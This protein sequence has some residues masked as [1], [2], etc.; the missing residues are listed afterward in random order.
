MNKIKEHI[1]QKNTTQYT[2]QTPNTLGTKTIQDNRLETIQR[3]K[4]QELMNA[5]VKNPIIQQKKNTT[6]LPDNLKTGIENLSGFSMDDVKVHYNSS[7]PAQLQAHAYAQGTDI[8]LAAGQEKHLPHEAWHVVQQ[9][10]GRVKPTKQLKSK[11]NINDDAGLEK[12]ADVMGAKALQFKS[13]KN[14]KFA[15]KL[16]INTTKVTQLKP[17]LSTEINTNGFN[18]I[19]ETHYERTLPIKQA[20]IKRTLEKKFIEDMG[21]KYWE[22]HEFNYENKKDGATV[23]GDNPELL[24][25][26]DIISL[27]Q[28]IEFMIACAKYLRGK[29]WDNDQDKNSTFVDN[30]C[31]YNNSLENLGHIKLRIEQ[32]ENRKVHNRIMKLHKDIVDNFPYKIA[33]KTFHTKK[34]LVRTFK[35]LLDIG[36][37]MLDLIGVDIK[38]GDLYRYDEKWIM[39]HK[40]RS[41]HM[42]ASA[43]IA[44]NENTK[45]VWKIGDN[46]VKDILELEKNNIKYTLMDKDGYEAYEEK[47]KQEISKE[48]QQGN[49]SF[50]LSSGFK[51]K[52]K[53]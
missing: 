25:I 29:D 32:F 7:K 22:E 20:K 30:D 42:N 10:Q 40:R 28:N 26:S 51:K 24:F 44:C 35:K 48:A 4:Q 19:G 27:N 21:L 33:L 8:H 6:G 38:K 18:V 53:D 49:L 5:T 31:I 1:P 41:S 46:H 47:K 37:E 11:V 16:S 12:E 14:E 23:F 15:E 34:S 17:Q 36:H 13:Q 45:G 52:K 39:N 2:K 3:K 9:K 43:K 50:L